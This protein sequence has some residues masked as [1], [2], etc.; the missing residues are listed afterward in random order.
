MK[1]NKMKIL[2]AGFF[3]FFVFISGVV[4][5]ASTKLNP[6]E[7]RKIAV[8]QTLKYFPNSEVKLESVHIKWGFNFKIE[9]VN[10]SL[11]TK[12]PEGKAFEMMSVDQLGVKIPL[13]A[14]LTNAG[15]VEIQL[16]KPLLNYAEFSEGNN[17]LYAMGERGKSDKDVDKNATK[18]NSNESEE[19]RAL[20]LFGK[21]KINVKLSDILVKY[22]LR[23]KSAGEINISRFLVKGLNFDTSTAFEIA[24]DAKFIMEDQSVVSF[25]TI[26]IGEVNISDMVKNGSVSTLLIVKI[27]NIKKTGLNLKIPEISTKINFL[28]K[29]NGEISGTL[30][31]SLDLQNKIS[32]NFKMTKEMEISNINMEMYLKDMASMSGLE[33]IVDLAKAKMQASGSILYTEDKKIKSRLQFNINPGISYSKDGILAT[34]TL[35]GSFIGTALSGR[36]KTDVLGGQVETFFS[37]E[38]DPSEKFEMKK[39]KPFDIKITASK[40]KISEDLIQEKMWAKK[41]AVTEPLEKF[42][43]EKNSKV[44][45]APWELPPANIAMNWSNISV[46]GENFSGR[47]KMVMSSNVV[48]IDDLSFKFS[49]GT[50]KLSQT[51]K[52][53]KKSNE[54]YFDLNFSDLNFSSFRAFFPP[55]IK[56][57][58]GT[59]SGKVNGSA[60]M[61]LQNVPPIYN[62][63]VSVDAK[64][65]EIKKLN[66]SEYLTPLLEKIPVIKEQVDKKGVKIDG[67]FETFKMNGKFSNEIYNL[68]NFN[69][70]GINKKIEINGSGVIYPSINAKKES[71][72]EASFSEN[73]KIGELLLKNTGARILPIKLSGLGFALSPNL[74]YTLQRIAK[75]AAKVKGKELAQKTLEKLVP[76]KTKEQVKG[77]LKGLFKRK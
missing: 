71:E 44:T 11:V 68:L 6:E 52:L 65:G 39:L 40:M 56:D 76:E 63:N 48:A 28:L 55:F 24:S 16:N 22:K 38:F 33:N 1:N 4:Y 75:E 12:G 53:G 73:G 47:G 77:L 41:H 5:Y 14:V 19:K 17:W 43:E 26:G 72:I 23:N 58:S 2:G 32:A 36:L 50:G 10:F 13:W 8:S 27:N 46:G 49:G 20:G 21:S 54:S 34:T 30:Q 64:K 51:I 18:E 61:F 7:I 66:I 15:V 35:D 69:F 45:S 62:V 74:E 70:V 67:N 31:T 42:P 37:G 57:F 3:L 59:A 29:K 9:L 60:T 25:N